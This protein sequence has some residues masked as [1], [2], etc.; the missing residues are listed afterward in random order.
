MAVLSEA[1]NPVFYINDTAF[2]Y[3]E[4]LHKAGV[5]N[6]VAEKIYYLLGDS[7]YNVRR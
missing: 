5:G 4:D 1:M 6:E 2:L 7:P 3:L